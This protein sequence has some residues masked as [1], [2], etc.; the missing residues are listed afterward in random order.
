MTKERDKL[1]TPSGSL[2]WVVTVDDNPMPYEIWQY[3]FKVV[4]GSE[5]YVKM[6]VKKLN[7]RR[8]QALYEY[9]QCTDPKILFENAKLT[10]SDK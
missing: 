4:V 7:A 6:L 9:S 10:Q 5:D 2:L 1:N 3:P 8:G